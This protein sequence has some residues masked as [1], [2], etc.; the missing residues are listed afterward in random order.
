MARKTLPDATGYQPDAELIS[1]LIDAC[2][3]VLGVK[4]QGVVATRIGVSATTLKDWKSGRRK[5]SYADQFTLEVL[6][7]GD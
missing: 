7:A 4:N 2:K 6:A 5:P 1:K 3:K